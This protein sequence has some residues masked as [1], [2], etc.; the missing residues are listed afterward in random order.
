MTPSQGQ[1]PATM[2]EPIVNLSE[3][4]YRPQE[5][6]DLSYRFEPPA[7]EKDRRELGLETPWDFDG[8]L[9]MTESSDFLLIGELRFTTVRPCARCLRPVTEHHRL[10]LNLVYRDDLYIHDDP[11]LMDE[12]PDG[13]SFE[14]LAEWCSFESLFPSGVPAPYLQKHSEHIL[15]DYPVYP[16][17]RGLLD[18]CPSLREQAFLSLDPR[19]LCDSN[20]QGIC[21]VCGRLKSDPLCHCEAEGKSALG[22]EPGFDPDKR[23]P[24]AGLADLLEAKKQEEVDGKDS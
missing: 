19:V 1:D 13:G 12:S 11:K 23:Y 15:S 4:I 20:C 2:D 5:I 6:L 7:D 18:L 24:F 21:P 16:Q 3:L 9:F 14:G 17:K 10:P 22:D 8:K